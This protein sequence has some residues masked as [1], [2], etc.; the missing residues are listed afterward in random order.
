MITEKDFIDIG[1]KRVTKEE[2]ERHKTPPSSYHKERKNYDKKFI[3]GEMM[4]FT[5]PVT[6]HLRYGTGYGK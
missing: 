5:K 4:Y 3:E 1:W 6:P 2:Y